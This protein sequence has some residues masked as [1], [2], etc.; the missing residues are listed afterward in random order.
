MSFG[1]AMRSHPVVDRLIEVVN[2]NQWPN[3]HRMVDRSRKAYE[4]GLDQVNR[5][6]GDPAIFF[7]ALQTFADT[8]SCVYAYAGIAFALAMA[9]AVTGDG[10]YD[11]GFEEALK[12]LEKAQEWEPNLVEINFIEA[13]VYL[14]WGQLENGRL[15]L[16]HLAQDNPKNYY[17][18]LTEMNY[19]SQQKDHDNYFNWLR[20]ASKSADN[21]LRQAYTLN[22]LANLYLNQGQYEKSIEIFADVVKFTPDDAWAW[23]NMSFMFLNLKKVKEAAMCNQ[24]ALEIMDFPAARDI[25]EKIKQNKGG[26]GRLF[27]K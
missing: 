19:W 24:R 8:K 5:Y 9:T 11:I 13:V 7:K 16:D 12:W 20:T 27:R 17:L 21:P 4:Y 15:I 22:A 2:Q 10:V 3:A 26:L 1:A 18:C 6:H 25:Q 14:N 23:H